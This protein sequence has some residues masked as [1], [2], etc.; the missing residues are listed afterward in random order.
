M[1][2]GSPE[3]LVTLGNLQ[4]HRVTQKHGSESK[5]TGTKSFYGEWMYYKLVSLGTLTIEM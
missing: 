5:V 2:A 3:A 1:D 4:R